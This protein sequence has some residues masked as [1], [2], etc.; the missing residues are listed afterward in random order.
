[1][2]N[3]LHEENAALQPFSTS[4]ELGYQSTLA[5]LHWYEASEEVVMS[6]IK[7]SSIVFAFV[8]GGALFGLFLHP[9][10]PK[11]YL[12]EDTK[13]VVRLGM[14]L[15][16][17]MAAMVLGL[18]VASAKN[19]YDAKNTALVEN[20]ARVVL[21]D[22]VLAHYGTETKEVRELLRNAY[23]R[24][25]ARIWSKNR[26]NP[27]G[28][29]APSTEVEV[30][31]DEIQKLSPTNETQGSLKTQAV[32]IAWGVGQT[33]WLLYE[34]QADSISTPVLVTVVFWL[35]ALFVSFGLFAQRDV[36]VV[37]SLF[38][39]A[40]SV[41]G[42]IFLIVEMYT[43]FSGLVQISRAPL[44]AAHAQLCR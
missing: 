26:M 14:A 43:P 34:Q 44:R 33:R 21:L 28:L 27:S 11:D 16:S 30:L 12:R 29:E 40:V 42:A 3:I 31:I 9:S 22:R 23:A 38:I 18:L 8:F 17:T 7:V 1:L 19:S 6:S 15:V 10:L 24:V 35:I 5:E 2:A 20:A 41:S 39:S 13:E 37:V 32:S 36:V 25:V 4:R